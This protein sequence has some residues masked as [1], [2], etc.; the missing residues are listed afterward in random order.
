MRNAGTRRAS[1]L[2]GPLCLLGHQP[3]ASP[4]LPQVLNAAS[5]NAMSITGAAYSVLSVYV[6]C[7]RSVYAPAT[8]C[9]VLTQSTFVPVK[10]QKTA[11]AFSPPPSS[12]ASLIFV[13]PHILHCEIHCF[14]LQ[15]VPELRRVRLIS[16]VRNQPEKVTC[17]CDIAYAAT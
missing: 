10:S 15:S 5:L 16:G 1:P 4:P 13:L 17:G 2:R 6:R 12:L 9:L 11:R 8:P 3:P 14:S 7:V